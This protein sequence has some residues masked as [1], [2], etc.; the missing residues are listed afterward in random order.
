MNGAVIFA[1]NNASVDYI[2]LAIFA[3]GRVKRYL[4]LPVSLITD[5]KKWLDKNYPNHP[6]DQIIEVPSSDIT[7]TKK[8]N[9]GAL[10]SKMLDWKNFSRSQV[11]D[12]TPY[13]RTLVLDSDYIINSSILKS[14]FL[15]DYDFQIYKASMDLADWRD[16]SEFQRISNYSI[17]FYWATV[18]VFQKNT[19][20]ESF[21]NLIEYIKFNWIYFKTLYAIEAPAYRNDYAFSIAIH[22]MNGKSVGDFAI[23]LPG[24]MIYTLDRDMLTSANDTDMQFLI[25]KQKHLGEYTAVKTSNLDIHVMNKFS[26]TR[27]I[28]EVFSE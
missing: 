11:Y 24:K 4:D 2:K 18:F 5:D 21:F 25:E 17:P 26:L 22:I 7:Q 1:H 19:I 23:E 10:S 20:M 16:S 14:A 15:N 6:F 8:F 12:L 9:D 3:A 13:D 27:H 28:D